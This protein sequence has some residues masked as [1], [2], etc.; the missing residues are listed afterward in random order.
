MAGSHELKLNCSRKLWPGGLADQC[1]GKMQTGCAE[2]ASLKM[3]IFFWEV[4]RE[5]STWG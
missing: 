3:E 4:E 5:R 2:E 1:G